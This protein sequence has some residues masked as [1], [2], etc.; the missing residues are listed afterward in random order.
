MLND[1]PLRENLT[2]ESLR[3]QRGT[4]SENIPVKIKVFDDGFEGHVRRS[5]ERIKK[6]AA[7]EHVEP[8]RSLTF[9]DPL[10]FFECFNPRR[11]RLIQAARKRPADIATL[12]KDVGRS[13]ASVTRDLKFLQQ[14]R[15]LR[16][17]P[18]RRPGQSPVQIVEPTAKKFEFYGVL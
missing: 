12:A 11:V 8:E 17:R 2:D 16:I 3:I 7:G 14:A 4:R 18:Q 15:L 10:D 9:G 6:V 13:V 5:L 1:C